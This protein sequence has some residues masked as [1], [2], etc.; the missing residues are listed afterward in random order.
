MQKIVWWTLVDIDTTKLR[1][2]PLTY[3][4]GLNPNP[5]KRTPHLTE[6]IGGAAGIFFLWIPLQHPIIRTV[7]TI[8]SLISITPSNTTSK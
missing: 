4:M 3:K 6:E 8:Q 2:L 7:P 1:Q 5:T